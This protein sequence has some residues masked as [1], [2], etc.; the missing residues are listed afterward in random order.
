MQY[1]GGHYQGG[2][3]PRLGSR[4]PQKRLYNTSS[5]FFCAILIYVLEV[6]IHTF[7]ITYPTVLTPRFAIYKHIHYSYIEGNQKCGLYS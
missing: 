3:S 7:K 4:S 6:G 5:D 2:L 1:Q